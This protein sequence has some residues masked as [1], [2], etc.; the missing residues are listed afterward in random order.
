[1]TGRPGLS[2]PLALLLVVAAFLLPGA[3]SAQPVRRGRGRVSPSS[4]SAETSTTSARSNGVYFDLYN[5]TSAPEGGDDHD[6]DAG[7]LRRLARPPL[8]SSSSGTPRWTPTAAPTRASSRS[9]RAHGVRLRSGDRRAAPKARTRPPGGWCSTARTASSASPSRVD[10]RGPGYRLTVCLGSLQKLEADRERGLFRDAVTSSGTRRSPATTASRRSSRRCGADGTPDPK[11]RYELRGDA[12]DPRGRAPDRELRPG[13][14]DADRHRH[15]H[16]RRARPRRH[17][18]PHLRRRDAATTSKQKELGVRRRRPSGGAYTLHASARD[19]AEAGST[20]TSTTTAT[21]SAAGGSL[22]P[23][24]VREPV[25]RRR[26][27]RRGQGRARSPPGPPPHDLRHGQP[28]GERR[29]S[30]RD[31]RSG[32][33][34]GCKRKTR[35][36]PPVELQLAPHCSGAT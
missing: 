36:A 11:T 32:S 8:P 35:S 9:R 23:G 27:H 24:R 12:A 33:R 29:A 26:R 13:D 18:R 20:P 15:A 4:W 16:R 14:E 7:R 31:G 19:R 5:L 25:H 22:G 1:M 21:R 17:Q 6:P 28:V 30:W 2:A 34:C 3:A 10:R